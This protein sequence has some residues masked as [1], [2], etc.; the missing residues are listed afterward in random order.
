[1]MTDSGYCFFFSPLSLTSDSFPNQRLASINGDAL[2]VVRNQIG[3]LCEVKK[4][5]NHND[6]QTR[7]QED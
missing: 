3:S 7:P 1:M 6:E 5:N 2:P 4:K